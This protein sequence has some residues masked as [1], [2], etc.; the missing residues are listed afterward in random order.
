MTGSSSQPPHEHP[1]SE[2]ERLEAL[3]ALQILDTPPEREF[4]DLVWLASRICETPIALVSLVDADRQW[5]KASCGIEAKETSRDISFCRHAL[6]QDSVFIVPDAALDP[7]FSSNPLVV[8]PPNIRFYA[9]APLISADGFR[10]GT[11]CVIDTLPRSLSGRQAEALQR[12]A[13]RTAE[14]LEH[15]R[16]RLVAEARE[17]ILQSLLDTMPDGVVTCDDDGQ[18]AEFNRTARLW[19]GVDPRAIPQDQWAEFFG[20]F[21]ASGTSQL[22]TQ[23][24]PLLRAWQGEHVRGARMTIQATGQRPR[25][26]ICNAAPLVGSE[27]KAAGAVC[28]MHD[29][30]DLDAAQR[31]AS[32]EAQRF[33][34]AFSAAAQGMALVALNGQWLEINDAL[35]AMFG[36]DRAELLHIELMKLVHPEELNVLKAGLKTLIEGKERQLQAAR[37][38]VHKSGATIYAHLSV[39]T[40]PSVAELTPHLVIQ[41]QDLTERHIAELR[42]QDSERQL[43]AIS[44]A[45]PAWMG[46]VNSDLTCEYVN[47]RYADHIGHS[48]EDIIGKPFFEFFPPAENLAL[49][50]YVELALMGHTTNFDLS[51]KGQKGRPLSLHVTLVPDQVEHGQLPSNR[52]GGFFFMIYDVTVQTELTRNFQK[53]AMTDALTGLPNRAAWTA[54]LTLAMQR[55]ES[56]GSAAAMLFLDLDGFKQINDT[57]GHDAGDFVLCEFTRRLTGCLRSS[58]YVARLAGDEFVVLLDNITEPSIQPQIIADKIVEAMEPPMQL[59]TATLNVK[60]SVGLAFQTSP[61]FNPEALMKAADAAMYRA[62]RSGKSGR[63]SS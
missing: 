32:A 57:H 37:R 39:S 61:P 44:D 53:K 24:I 21:D 50:S 35:C 56:T 6:G 41:L 40:V 63:A 38:F 47:Q 15:R 46:R 34:D 8:G 18:L 4:D 5:F 51:A 60:P 23:D 12:L 48:R 45:V 25:L 27:G 2:R 26:L 36:F 55:A 17:R 10:Y 30:T 14:A 31:A 43:R 58:D 42:L 33:N 54:E 28:N 52:N 29:I 19:H 11:L 49:S 22:K 7:R 20:L 13:R 1:Q 9:G 16:L 62:K 59:G 3:R